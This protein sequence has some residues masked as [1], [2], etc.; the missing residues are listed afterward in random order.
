MS[1]LAISAS[2]IAKQ[3]EVGAREATYQTLREA[4]MGAVAM[5][6]R[7]LRRLSGTDAAAE[8]FWAL[9]D[10]SFDVEQ[11]EVLGIIGRNGAGKSTLLK[12]LARIT[13]PTAG[14][15]LIRGRVASLLEVGTGFHSEL[16]G[17]ENIFLNGAILGMTRAEIERKFDDIVAFAEVERFLDTPVK[18]YSSGMYMRLAFAV[19]ANLDP[20]VLLVDEV[21]AV[22][23]VNF[24]KKCIDRMKGLAGRNTT[25]VFVSHNMSAIQ[26]LC[27]RCLLLDKGL[28]ILVADTAEVIKRYMEAH[29]P[30][31]AFSRTAPPGEGPCLLEASLEVENSPDGTG[32]GRLV[33][34][35]TLHAK[36]VSRVGLWFRIRDQIGA[37]VAI[38][39]LGTCHADEML[40]LAPGRTEL[41]CEIDIASLALGDYSLSITTI[42]P[43]V[44]VLDDVEDCLAFSV[45]R[46]PRSGASRAIA[47]S[48]GYGSVQL[49]ARH[50]G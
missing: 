24:Q 1:T 37:P 22:G 23:D 7:R 46:P 6:F 33:I 48:W 8:R 26:S 45:D 27:N 50:I 47:Q 25:V 15:V 5:P 38:A 2:G 16:T 19:A 49:R 4:I 12:V 34:R 40:P 31:R 17:R 28:S 10:V 18:R 11:G 35:G 32:C 44:M 14:R 9:R 36:D 13:E 43:G 3:Y 41:S 30:A 20:E 42:Q 39:E 21:L 29:A